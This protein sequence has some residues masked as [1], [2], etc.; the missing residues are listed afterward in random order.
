[1]PLEKFE[2]TF[3]GGKN[4]P[5]RL[6]KDACKG[7]R[8]TAIGKLTGHNGAASDLTAKLKV[9]GCPPTVTLKRKGGKLRAT[10][11]PGR[12]GAKIRSTKVG[13]RTKKGY[14][15]TVKD[16]G[17]ETWKLVVKVRR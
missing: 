11:K 6:A 12:D 9:I 14:K 7:A 16:R 10:A 17:G 1:V 3:T 2:L 4:S 15:V 13:A 5:L 8:Q